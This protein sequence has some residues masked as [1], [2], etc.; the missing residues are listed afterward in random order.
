ML[1]IGRYTIPATHLDHV[2]FPED[3]ISEGDLLDYYRRIAPIMLPHVKDRPV[4]MHRFP[5]GIAKPGFY[6]KD[7]GSSFP[8]WVDRVTVK[9]VGGTVT[10]LLINKS[11]T[12]AYLAD[13]ACITPHVWLSRKDKLSHPDRLIFD[14]DHESGDF[15]KIRFAA[16]KLRGAL[17][18]LR[19]T[20]FLMTTGSRGL[21]VVIPLDRRLPFDPV[22]A[23]ARQL[24][25]RL[26]REFPLMLT[27]EAR[28]T[29]RR[30][31]V[32]IDTQR[33]GY[34]QTSVPPYAVRAR[35]GA[36]V[37]APLNWSELNRP[38][39]RSNLYTI[40]SISQRLGRLGDPWR[41]IDRR[42]YSLTAA[43]RRL[44]KRPG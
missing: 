35:A 43:S 29:K 15:E 14:L 21:H 33:N 7:I 24:A 26:A 10:H 18:S 11:A 13:A 31:R 1:R 32:L 8:D 36:P 41:E 38:N 42:P 4:M 17:V 44:A 12:L 25:E 37:A 40:R 9:K 5:G 34:A 3:G 6:Q 19:L 2:L 22:R 30:G 28:K 23:F 16:G 27:V 20:P 39:L